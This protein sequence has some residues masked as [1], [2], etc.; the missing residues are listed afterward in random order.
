[1]IFLVVSII[2]WIIGISGIIH[3]IKTKSDTWRLISMLIMFI[4]V[5]FA[6]FII[7]PIEYGI[8]LI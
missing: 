3:F 4:L 7:L 8:G 5:F 1:M 2:G 6:V